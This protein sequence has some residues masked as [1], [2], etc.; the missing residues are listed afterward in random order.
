MIP[1]SDLLHSKSNMVEH[2]HVIGCEEHDSEDLEIELG[3]T[4]RLQP[5]GRAPSQ[6]SSFLEPDVPRTDQTTVHR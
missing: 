5:H 3:E 6:D 1:R 2:M 4:V